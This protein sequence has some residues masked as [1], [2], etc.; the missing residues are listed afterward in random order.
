MT[1]K[2]SIILVRPRYAG[3]IGSVA[4]AMKNMGLSRLTLVRPGALPGHPEALR[5]A[6]D[7]KDILKRS[8]I[9]DSLDEA[10]KDF[11]FVLGTSRREGKHRRDF[12][13]STQV[14]DL[15]KKQ[16]KGSRIAI[17]FGAEERG[18]TNEELAR[19]HRVVMIPSSSKLPS[20]NLAQSVMVI[21]YELFSKKKAKSTSPSFK[22]SPLASMQELEGMYGQMEEALTAVKFFTDDHHFHIM[23]TLRTI[24][25][26]AHPTAREIRI[27]RGI[28][29]QV[30]W[31]VE[32]MRSETT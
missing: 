29:R 28:W 17:L 12:L 1:R 30:M 27:F 15:L 26:R 19:C 5:L 2:V 21:A 25:G 3:N 6:V 31:L 18:L 16:P 10:L 14:H 32:K 20:L 4:R 7:A 22:E 24:F 23:R 13:L 8:Q 9:V 11:N